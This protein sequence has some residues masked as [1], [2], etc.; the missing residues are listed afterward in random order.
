MHVALWNAKSGPD[1]RPR[2]FSRLVQNS[3]TEDHSR[4]SEIELVEYVSYSWSVVIL[5]P[6]CIVTHA[7]C[8]AA[9][10]G[11]VFSRICLSVCPRSNRK[12]AWSINTKLIY[13]IVVARH[14]LAQ[15][16]KG[17]RLGS[18]GYENRHG[19]TVASDACRYGRVLPWCAMY[20]RFCGCL[21]Q[22][23]AKNSRHFLGARN[24]TGLSCGRGTARRSVRRS[25][26]VF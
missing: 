14:K 25:G 24:S 11:R 20:F 19:R 21:F 22:R 6:I 16:S 18:H 4:S 10:V 23:G 2:F 9:G 15:R 5:S 3:P 13:S 8:I 1:D 12:T 26:N 7:G 17:Q